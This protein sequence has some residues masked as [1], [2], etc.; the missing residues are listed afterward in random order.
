MGSVFDWITIAT[1]GGLAALYMLRSTE[2]EPRDKVWHYLPPALGC[3]VANK[4]GNDGYSVL[5]VAGVV[6]VL[7]WIYYV[8]EPRFEL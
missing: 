8:L 5:A 6:A 7:A 2:E 3:A 1:F 4:V